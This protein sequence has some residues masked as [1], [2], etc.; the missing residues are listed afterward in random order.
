MANPDCPCHS[1][2]RL[3]LC[4][5]PIVRGEREAADPEALMRSRYTAFATGAVEH[6]WRTLAHD[7][8]DRARPRDEVLAEL[9]RACRSN[10]YRRLRILDRSG[11]DPA[12]LARVLFHAAIFE[13]GRDLSFVELSRFRHDGTGW[14]YLGGDLRPLPAAAD[15]S[16][17]R[18]E[19]FQLP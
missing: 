16:A 8:A 6:L 17:L 19:T 18:L 14:R 5:G 3:H 11:A 2:L 4:C 1:G 9:R 10:R 15:P 7:H 13:S 12:G